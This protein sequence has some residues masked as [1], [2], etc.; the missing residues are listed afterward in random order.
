[1]NERNELLE[2]FFV[3][4]QEWGLPAGAIESGETLGEAGAR[5]LVERTGLAINAAD[6]HIAGTIMSGQ[7]PFALLV[8]T[9]SKTKKVAE[10]GEKGGYMTKIRWRKP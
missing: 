6:L 4:K 3:R 8:A 5:E 7:T 10:P 2:H 9:K 1:M